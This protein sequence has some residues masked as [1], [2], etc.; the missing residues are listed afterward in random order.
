M[1]IIW[2]LA[3][4]LLFVI[5]GFVIYR[6]TKKKEKSTAES[7]SQEENQETKADPLRHLVELNLE[8]RKAAI[9][10]ELTH[11]CEAVIDQLVDLIPTVNNVSQPGSELVWTVNRI[12][13]EYL[14][15]KC[16]RPYLALSDAARREVENIDTMKASLASLNKELNDV[17]AMLDKKDESEFEAKAKFL[18]HK[19]NNDT[20]VA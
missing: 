10:S 8:I 4:S 13:S 5:I 19:F 6:S 1:E 16:I 15:N 9:A 7:T 3:L 11:R 17:K 12:A 20:G 18:K 2:G 14:P